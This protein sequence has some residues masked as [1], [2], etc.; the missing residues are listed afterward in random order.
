MAPEKQRAKML[1]IGFCDF[2]RQE[3]RP[4]ADK[5]AQF[6]DKQIRAFV[7]IRGRTAFPNMKSADNL[8]LTKGNAEALAKYAGLASRTYARRVP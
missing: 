8:K 6:I 4:C 3:F 5:S 2:T 1:V 7:T